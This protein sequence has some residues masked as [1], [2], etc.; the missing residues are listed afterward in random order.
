MPW[1]SGWPLSGSHCCGWCLVAIVLWLFRQCSVPVPSRRVQL[2]FSMSGHTAPKPKRDVSWPLPPWRWNQHLEEM[3]TRFFFHLKAFWQFVFNLQTNHA[4]SLIFRQIVPLTCCCPE[5]P[6][7]STLSLSGW[8]D[9]C[10]V[11]NIAILTWLFGLVFCH[12]TGS[13]KGPEFLLNF[14]FKNKFF[15]PISKFM[16]SSGPVLLRD[17]IYIQACSKNVRKLY[18]AESILTET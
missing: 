6:S 17:V 2:R 9:I 15:L 4:L 18:L 14:F 3:N 13:S 11:G 12:P 5:V 10:Y 7:F 16:F 8:S 1:R